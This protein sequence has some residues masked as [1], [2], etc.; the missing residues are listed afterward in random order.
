MAE[1]RIVLSLTEEDVA[2][3]SFDPAPE[4][5]YTV[6]I[7]SVETRTSNSQKN[8]G[9]PFYALEYTS[10]DK[11]AFAGKF[12][13]NVMLWHGAHFSLVGLAKALGIISGPGEL[14][15]PT[16]D[17]LLGQEFDVFVKIAEYTNKNDELAKRNEVKRYRAKGGAE[18]KPAAKGKKAA[19]KKFSL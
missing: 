12:F 16:E 13:D 4:G 18:A 11:D 1:D 6:E 14:V 10:I 9:K 17:E 15:V 2:E 3:R 5:W 7:T 8:P 19:D